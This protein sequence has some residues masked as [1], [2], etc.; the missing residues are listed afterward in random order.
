MAELDDLMESMWD[1]EIVN[2]QDA[3]RHAYD[4]TH[5]IPDSASK[6]VLLRN[7]YLKTKKVIF[8]SKR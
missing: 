6:S 7:D 4:F 2:D 1:D 3:T 5:S 8:K